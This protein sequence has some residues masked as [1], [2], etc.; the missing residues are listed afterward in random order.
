MFS[1]FVIPA[2]VGKQLDLLFLPCA[3]V[4]Y[5]S[6]QTPKE[7]KLIC[8]RFTRVMLLLFPL[9]HRTHHRNRDRTMASLID[10]AMRLS[11]GPSATRAVLTPIDKDPCHLLLNPLHD[12]TLRPLL[13]QQKWLHLTQMQH[14]RLLKMPMVPPPFPIAV[15]PR[16]KLRQR[17]CHI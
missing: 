3:V 16:P 7:L 11:N 2:H 1:F 5:L 8:V 17:R 10:V 15:S 14:P 6:L 13:K 4:A 12:T 9:M